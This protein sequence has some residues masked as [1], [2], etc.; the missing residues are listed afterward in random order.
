MKNKLQESLKQVGNAAV[1]VSEKGKQM[2]N[3]TMENVHQLSAKIQDE[4]YKAMLKKYNPVFPEVNS[5]HQQHF[6]QN[7]IV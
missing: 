6:C 1:Q 3:S 2:A 5:E 4:S 7:G